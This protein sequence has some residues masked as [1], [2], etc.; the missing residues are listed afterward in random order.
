MEKVLVKEQIGNVAE[1]QSLRK[2]VTKEKL[3]VTRQPR[4]YKQK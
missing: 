3:L 4:F 2:N 1:F